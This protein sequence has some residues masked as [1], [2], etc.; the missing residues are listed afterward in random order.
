[1]PFAIRGSVAAAVA[2]PDWGARDFS[3][4]LVKERGDKLMVVGYDAKQ[5]PKRPNRGAR[6]PHLRGQPRHRL[7]VR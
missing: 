4:L 3:G 5:S 1:M 6:R 2:R 7:V